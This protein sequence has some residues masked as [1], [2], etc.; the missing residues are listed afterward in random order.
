MGTH[1]KPRTM[2]N[3]R[4]PAVGCCIYCRATGDL[5]DEHIIPLG[6]N[7]G[8][9]LPDASCKRCAEKTSVFEREILRGEL[10]PVRAAFGYPTR[11]R[12]S[13]PKT[14]PFRISRRGKEETVSVPLSEY[15]LSVTF[16]IFA[17]ELPP[18]AY[19]KSVLGPPVIKSVIS[20][21]FGEDHR[22]R[23]ENLLKKY[24]A[25]AA[26]T[27]LPSRPFARLIAKIALGICIYQ[28]GI[29]ALARNYVAA[30][31]LGETDS[32]ATYVGSSTDFLQPE[33]VQHTTQVQTY[34]KHGFPNELLVAYIRTLSS[35]ASPAYIVVVGEV[36][37]GSRP[38]QSLTFDPTQ[39]AN[40]PVA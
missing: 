22:D 19:G 25:D 29:S 7:G 23:M 30:D 18:I 15:P 38:I 31:I 32:L 14:F 1:R 2:L 34:S 16:P 4:L 24:H 3:G 36:F 10:W 8:S 33:L 21:R 37:P 13:Q 26:V 28:F 39:T 6:L 5:T 35:Y 20:V 40:T 11:R 27:L 9:I 17:E 12:R